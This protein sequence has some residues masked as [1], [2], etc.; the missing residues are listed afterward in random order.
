LRCLKWHAIHKLRTIFVILILYFIGQSNNIVN[1]L[2]TN[3]TLILKQRKSHRAKQ[4]RELMGRPYY[5]NEKSRLNGMPISIQYCNSVCLK[6]GQGSSTNAVKS[7]A[8]WCLASALLKQIKISCYTE[9]K[10]FGP[11]T[12]LQYYHG[13]IIHWGLGIRTKQ[14]YLN[15]FTFCSDTE[16]PRI[17]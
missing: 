2:K 4:Y 11:V 12:N 13:N 5:H 16:I 3:H 14:G 8:K 15:Y 6:S 1:I 7:D 9:Y 17:K 10:V